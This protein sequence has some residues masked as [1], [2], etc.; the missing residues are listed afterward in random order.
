MTDK[1][2]S[3][4][5]KLGELSEEYAKTKHNKATNLHLGILRAKIARI[6]KEIVASGKKSKGTGFFVKKTGDATVALI[7]FPSAGKSSLI[8]AL[9]NTKSKTAQY[10]FT[11]TSIVP[12]T[13]LYNDAHIQVFDMPGLIEDAHLGAGG[14][15]MV[16][17]GMKSADLIVFVID[18]N[19]LGQFE[20][21]MHELE[22]LDIKINKRKPSIG[23]AEKVNGGIH[24]EVNRSGLP[25]HD[26]E[27]IL[28]G[29]GIHSADVSI[30]DRVGEDELISLVSGR[31]QYMNAIAVLNKVD[32]RPDYQRI[33]AD[34]EKK[35]SI[36]TMPVSA[37]EQ[38]NIPALKEVIYGNLGIITV[39]LKPKA[40]DERMM[41]MILKRGATIG[42]AAKKFH[43]QIVDELKCA[44]IKGRSAKFSNQKVGVTHTL[45][46][47]DII[48]FIKNK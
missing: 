4:T 27:E 14:G 33:T 44:Q 3:L 47:G 17:S 11:T 19:M 36:S 2:E 43:T 28:K 5:T 46:D 10:A 40:G 20:K 12:G 37:T 8:N 23:I 7:G 24:I 42:D 32:T 31:A 18:I 25:K 48:T 21:L 13:M 15:R 29:L 38:I 45:S 16:I 22:E 26:V 39:Y 9:C 1:A 41:P 35:H 34:F 30:W 6:R